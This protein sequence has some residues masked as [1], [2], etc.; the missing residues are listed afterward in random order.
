MNKVLVL[1]ACLLFYPH[2]KIAFQVSVYRQSDFVNSFLFKQMVSATLVG[3][4]VVAELPVPSFRSRRGIGI[5][6]FLSHDRVRRRHGSLDLRSLWTASQHQQKNHKKYSNGDKNI[7]NLRVYKFIHHGLPPLFLSSP[8][9]FWSPS[10][11]FSRFF[12]NFTMLSCLLH[13]SFLSANHISYTEARCQ[14][15]LLRLS[16]LFFSHC[17][18]RS[19]IRN[20]ISFSS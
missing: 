7:K 16:Q 15:I 10:S 13:S 6:D 8:S 2:I 12:L 9:F 17:L 5:K 20:F 19:F 4:P 3:C 11:H 18:A 14:N 1:R